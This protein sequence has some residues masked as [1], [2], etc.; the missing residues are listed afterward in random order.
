MADK[1]KK[2]NTRKIDDDEDEWDDTMST[3]E[4]SSSAASADDDSFVVEESGESSDESSEDGLFNSDSEEEVSNKRHKPKAT[5]SARPPLA[6]QSKQTAAVAAATNKKTATLMTAITP[7]MKRKD[8]PPAR[9][10]IPFDAA[11][12][13]G[14][15][16]GLN[17]FRQSNHALISPQLSQNSSTAASPFFGTPG[18][19]A[20][21]ATPSTS[22]SQ[23]SQHLLL[24]E[25]VV[26]RG[27]HEHNSFPFLL[28]ENR[29][30]AAG[31]R[32]GHAEYNPRTLLVPAKFLQDQTPAMQ[33]WW[34]LKAVN[35]DTVL[36]FK[37]YLYSH[38]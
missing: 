9:V 27:S 8:A 3:N 18:S 22:Q 12:S 28:P 16:Q 26:G 1:A 17:A 35:M 38:I 30:D 23:N 21:T 15:K 4:K 13:S 25:G 2:S 24:P 6:P 31:N 11:P 19:A 36:F 37:V 20:S 32:P 29:K 33:Q 7:D 5:S 34:Q 10:L 14:A